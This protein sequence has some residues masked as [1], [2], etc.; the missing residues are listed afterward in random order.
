DNISDNEFKWL[1]VTM[2]SDLFFDTISNI[3]KRKDGGDWGYVG[4]EQHNLISE[5]IHM[6]HNG[7]GNNSAMFRRYSYPGLLNS[8]N[9]LDM[10][11]TSFFA[12]IVKNNRNINS[13]MESEKILWAK[14]DGWYAH[15]DENGNIIFDVAIFKNGSYDKMV[16]IIKSHVKFETLQ[17][18]YSA[19]TK[20]VMEII[21][22]YSNPVINDTIN[23]YAT[24]FMYDTRRLIINDEVEA[25]RLIIP[26]N[27]EK[28]NIGMYV[29]VY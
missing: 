26:E 28:S 3:F 17:E 25:G 23:Y 27:P 8:C 18:K 22:K 13:F 14:I 7:T 19:L 4:F 6:W 2:A 10:N 20:E 29:T 21:K 11:Y 5:N 12:D 1:I 15:T 16:D 24:M 9:L